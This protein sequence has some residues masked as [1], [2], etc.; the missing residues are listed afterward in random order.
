MMEN[1]LL[2]DFGESER[3]QATLLLERKRLW[4]IIF[5]GILVNSILLSVIRRDS[6]DWFYGVANS[7]IGAST[8][9]LIFGFILG[10]LAAFIPYQGLAYG[11]KY[12]RASQ[13]S[14][15]FFSSIVMI[16]YLSILWLNWANNNFR[17]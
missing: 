5:V 14:M 13:W 16:A 1:E 17:L 2:D 6:A 3:L 4:Y 8:M 15:V 10:L 12:F 7:V 9:T 11:Q